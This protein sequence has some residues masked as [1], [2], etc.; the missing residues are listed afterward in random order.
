MR[1]VQVT[2]LVGLL[3]TAS[4]VPSQAALSIDCPATGFGGGS[5]ASASFEMFSVIGQPAAGPASSP[6]FFVESGLL[7]CFEVS[8]LVGVESG[9]PPVVSGLERIAPNPFVTTTTILFNLAAAAPATVRLFDTGGRLVRTL[10]QGRISPGRHA[11]EWDGTASD[12]HP[13]RAGV[14]Y[15]QFRSGA[16]LETRRLIFIK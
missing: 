6:T 12:G 8:S 16:T 4:H 5:A 3:V 9:D 1:S 10:V 14:Y 15:C 13:S 7:P 2:I 11:V